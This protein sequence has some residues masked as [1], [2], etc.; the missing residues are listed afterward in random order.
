VRGA[1]FAL[2]PFLHQVE[3]TELFFSVVLKV[4]RVLT[5]CYRRTIVR[6]SSQHLAYVPEVAVDKRVGHRDRE[7]DPLLAMAATR[8]FTKK[9]LCSVEA[10]TTKSGLGEFID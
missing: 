8:F 3:P 2:T 5:D 4:L 6:V 10:S 7:R 1:L 9:S